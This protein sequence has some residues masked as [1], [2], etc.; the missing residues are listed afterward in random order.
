MDCPSGGPTR[1]VSAS[2]AD[3]SNHLRIEVMMRSGQRQLRNP[4][5]AMDRQ[6]SVSLAAMMSLGV[7][8]APA[9]RK[10]FPECVDLRRRFSNLAHNVCNPSRRRGHAS[11]LTSSTSPLSVMSESKISTMDVPVESKTALIFGR[12]DA[13]DRRQVSIAESVILGSGRTF[14]ALKGPPGIN[15][16]IHYVQAYE[17]CHLLR[18]VPAGEAAV[19]RCC[20]GY[21]LRR[22][23]R[24]AGQ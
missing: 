15:P 6:M 24:A 14:P 18:A 10:P 20:G 9:L 3:V 13:L 19:H 1:S 11:W 16:I 8:M 2:R 17:R 21:R 5:L 22:T 4:A 23:G 12:C 7:K